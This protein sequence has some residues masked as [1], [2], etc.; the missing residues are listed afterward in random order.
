MSPSRSNAPDRA[1]GEYIV[2]ILPGTDAASL[3]EL[4]A[5]YGVRAVSDMGNGYMLIK[6]TRDPGL[7]EIQQKGAAS[8]KIKDVQPNFIYRIQ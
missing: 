2:S 4:Y 3:R 6:L 8:G 1:P 5:P 7:A